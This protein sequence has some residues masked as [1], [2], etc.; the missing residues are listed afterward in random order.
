MAQPPEELTGTPQAAPDSAR[1]IVSALRL[2]GAIFLEAEFTAP[3]CIMAQVGPE[4][5]APF[6]P[7][8]RH[9]IAYHCVTEGSCVVAPHGCEPV[10]VDAGEIVILPRNDPHLMGS[11]P[12]LRPIDAAPLIRPGAAGGL[13]RIVHGGGGAPTRL[14]CGY[15]GCDLAQPPAVALLPRILS[16]PAEGGAGWIETSFR[17]AADRLAAGGEAPA[18]LARLAELLFGE[19]VRRHLASDA[20]VAGCTAGLRDPVVARALACM[21]E[22]LARRWTTEA[23]AARCNLSRSA[24]AERFTRLVGDPPLRY[25]ARRRLERARLLLEETPDSLALIAHAVGYESEATFSRAFCREHG[26]PPATWRRGG[27]G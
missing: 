4:D 1:E 21:H 2:S 27:A 3:W 11:T 19:A 5:C 15:L 12:G 17:F 8:P 14:F 18:M 25:L 16:V 13:A 23:L 20:G 7:V 22:D 26:V 9:I 6:A 10:R 24:F